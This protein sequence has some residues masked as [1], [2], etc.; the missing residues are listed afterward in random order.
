MPSAISVV[1]VSMG[2]L[3]VF[4]V[5]NAV[6]HETPERGLT[7][8]GFPKNVRHALHCSEKREVSE[9]PQ[10]RDRRAERHSATRDEIL[11]AAWKQVSERGLA[12]L[13]LRDLAAAVGMRAPSLYSY[14]ASKNDIYDAMFADGNREFVAHMSQIEL[15]DDPALD[16]R[17]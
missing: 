9:M 17:R 16:L 1:V 5:P 12:G 15:T 13:S 11:Q 7:S 2:F 3:P 10:L 14:F 8:R 4:G 6:R